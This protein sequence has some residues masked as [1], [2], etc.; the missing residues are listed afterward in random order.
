MASSIDYILKETNLEKLTYVG[1]SQGTSEG[2]VLTT[3][4]PE[5]NDKLN[6]MVML[7]PIAYMEHSNSPFVN[8][9]ADFKTIIKVIILR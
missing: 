8:M 5:Y 9:I 3:S 2:L 7:S 1:H 4:R 6:L